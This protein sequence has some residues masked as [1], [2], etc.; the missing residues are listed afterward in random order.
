[1]V[2]IYENYAYHGTF[3]NA[4][5]SIEKDQSFLESEL[6]KDHWLGRGVYFFREDE[7]QALLWA[8]YKIK[9]TK[10]LEKQDSS[11]VEVILKVEDNKYLNLDTRRGLATLEKHITEM[12]KEVRVIFNSMDHAN[13]EGLRAYLLSLLPDD[14]WVIQRSFLVKSVFDKKNI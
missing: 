6:N 2:K 14:I 7:E 11:V 3:G 5:K 10:K 12:D 4:A 13:V 9:N 8:N 1:M